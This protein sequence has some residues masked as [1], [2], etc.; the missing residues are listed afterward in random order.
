M[1]LPVQMFHSRT[2]VFYPDEP[3]RLIANDTADVDDLITDNL[4]HI[5][6]GRYLHVWCR[7]AL[8]SP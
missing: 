3:N 7:I 6:A 4:L 8:R 2:I 1:K 5:R